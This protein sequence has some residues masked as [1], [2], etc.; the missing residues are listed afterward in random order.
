M[1]RIEKLI[2]LLSAA[3]LLCKMAVAGEIKKVEEQIF[4][5]NPG[6]VVTIIGDAG[7]ISVNAWDKN[8]AQLTITKTVWHRSK[9]RAEEL[10]AELKID[11]SHTDQRLYIRQPEFHRHANFRFAEVFDSDRWQDGVS[12]K[13]DF[14][15]NLPRE[16]D[17]R[18]END[19]GDVQINGVS[20]EIR[21]R[22]DEGS[23]FLKDSKFRRLE[24]GADEGDVVMES[25]G[26][27]GADAY[28]TVDEGELRILDSQLATA[29][30]ESDE[31]DII[32]KS[33]TLK[34]GDI[35]TD[36][37]EIVVDVAL[38][39]AGYCKLVTDEGDIRLVLPV[40]IDAEFS[41]ETSQGRIRSD[42]P[43]TIRNADADGEDVEEVLGKGL[44]RIRAYTENGD[45]T[46]QKK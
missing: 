7:S 11:I 2:P 27:L 14:D 34:D 10:M 18:I 29:N 43:L 42:F 30:F 12:I 45:I 3:A 25:I 16:A 31:G 23:V 38:Q 19:E 4:K 44:V 35:R 1:S 22:A 17:L 41:L 13:V 24:I 33:L 32:L 28:I 39:K 15:L 26:G 46:I 9:S 36:E 40:D 37:G 21:I 8:E 6:A 5:I 20:G